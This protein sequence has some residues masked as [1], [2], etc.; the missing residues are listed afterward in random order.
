MRSRIGLA[1]REAILLA[2]HATDGELQQLLRT[3]GWEV[4]MTSDVASARDWI[5][6][7][8]HCVGVVTL[9]D[10]VFASKIATSVE[11]L[12]R[13]TN[14]IEWIGLIEQRCV[15]RARAEY[16]LPGIFYDYH[17][18]PVDAARLLHTLGH[19]AG[20]SQVKH[21]DIATSPTLTTGTLL[22]GQSK[23]MQSVHRDIAKFASV[24]APVMIC[25]ESGTGKEL[26]AQL[27]HRQ[28]RRAERPFIAINCGALQP[29]LIRSELFGH[30][31]GA[32]TSAHRQRIGKLE[33][34]QH[35]TL[36]LDEIGDLSLDLQAN[37]LRFLQEHTFERLGGSSSITVDTR[38]ITAT[39][40]DL[41]Q[42]VGAGTFREDLYYRLNVLNL[43]MPPLRDRSQD[44]EYLAKHYFEKLS[45]ER[46]ANVK[47]FS[48]SAL[49]AL[50]QHDWPGN[51]RELINRVRRATV[52]CEKRLIT[53]SDLDLDLER[54]EITSHA[55]TI[56]QARESAERR[57]IATTLDCTAH[58]V[59]EA[60]KILD[61]SRGTL[62]RLMEK[63][64]LS[65]SLPSAPHRQLHK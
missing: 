50:R 58:N 45:V 34:A 9:C 33:L 23:A 21:R 48:R 13:E 59:S 51:V 8:P 46:T 1:T 29:E 6:H 44:V 53:P 15:E 3:A 49:R 60:A 4:Y 40:V 57:A 27:I 18:L 65:N 41:S 24:D 28:S 2:P 14:A 10:A 7:H 55:M 20:M 39:H 25:G 47:G 12:L 62:Y 19:A 30:E 63:H 5:H 37:L 64:G 17:T 43:E 61:V 42:A 35:G 38:V 52:M 54:P 32:F 56:S 16:W 26:A 36:F 31:K 11:H 22:V